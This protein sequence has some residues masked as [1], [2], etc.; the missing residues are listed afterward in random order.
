[1][2][3]VKKLM[4]KVARRKKELQKFD[5]LPISKQRDLDQQGCNPHD[6]PEIRKQKKAAYSARLKER[7]PK[8]AREILEAAGWFDIS[9]E[10]I[11][12][13]ET[14]TISASTGEKR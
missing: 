9:G 5:S 3:T 13:R 12:R 6:A 10:W 7:L 14:G 8:E 11:N 4:A 1:M 2:T